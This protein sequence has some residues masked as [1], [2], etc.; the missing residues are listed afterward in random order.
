MANTV[1]FAA[2]RSLVGQCDV[3]LLPGNLAVLAHGRPLPLG[4][5][6]RL[7]PRRCGPSA[8]CCSTAHSR[9]RSWSLWERGARVYV[10]LCERNACMLWLCLHACGQERMSG[11]MCQCAYVQAPAGLG[12]M[13]ALAPGAVVHCCE[14]SFLCAVTPCSLELLRQIEAML[15]RADLHLPGVQPSAPLAVCKLLP[16]CLPRRWVGMTGCI[17]S[18]NRG[19]P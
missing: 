13:C 11:W 3:C 8:S 9:A 7:A 12:C 18:I 17:C 14:S 1:A 4:S 6:R 16:G 2:A 10:R 19:S 15:A 5:L